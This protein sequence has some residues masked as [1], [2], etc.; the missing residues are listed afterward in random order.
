MKRLAAGRMN[1]RN[2]VADFTALWT[3]EGFLYVAA[4]MDLFS[5]RIVG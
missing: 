1:P 4:V 2:T 5:R 3:G